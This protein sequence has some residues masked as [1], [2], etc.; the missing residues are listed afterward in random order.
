MPE[1]DLDAN[2]VESWD[3]E[4]KQCKNCASFQCQGEACICANYSDKSFAEILAD[5]GEISPQGH[6]DYFQSMD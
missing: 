1:R 3:D 2:Y 6:C 5:Y 4:A